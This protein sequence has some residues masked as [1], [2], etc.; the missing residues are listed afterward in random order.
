MNIVCDKCQSRFNIPADKIPAGKTVTLK[1]PKCENRIFVPASPEMGFGDSSAEDP[2]ERALY[3]EDERPL[4]FVDEDIQTA[5]ICEP[6][7]LIKSRIVPVLTQLRYQITEA[8]DPRMALRNMRYHV[9]ELIIL[10]EIFGS[11]D[12]NANGILIYLE[13]MG[14]AVRRNI[15]VVLLS[16]RFRTMDPMMAFNKSVDLI[17]NIEN[18]NEFEK[19]LT[20]GIR[21]KEAFYRVFKDTM[22]IVGRM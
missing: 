12:P 1:C 15:F 9:Y 14:M 22:K 5:L 3:D 11:S 17:I 13:R 6:D 18:L 8:A 7:E 2:A 10:N 4:G 16:E 21:Q 20:R 19:I